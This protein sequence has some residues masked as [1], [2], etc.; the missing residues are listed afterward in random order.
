[1]LDLQTVISQNFMRHA[2]AFIIDSRIKNHNF[3]LRHFKS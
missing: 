3:A 2:H 1:M